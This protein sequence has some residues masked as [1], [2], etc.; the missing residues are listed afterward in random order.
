M[1]QGDD[2][3]DPMLKKILTLRDQFDG[4]RHE[5][6]SNGKHK[7]TF[8]GNAGVTEKY[9]SCTTGEF[10][11]DGDVVNYSFDQVGDNP[12][13]MMD[14]SFEEIDAALSENSGLF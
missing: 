1:A 3:L 8:N 11:L 5:V 6:K 4:Y 9:P 2:G 13:V 10:E 14:T 7:Y 12:V